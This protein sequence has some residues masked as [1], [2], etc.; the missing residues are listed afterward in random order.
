D[1]AEAHGARWNA[2]AANVKADARIGGSHLM[3]VHQHTHL[4]ANPG[5]GA[6]GHCL[7]KDFAAFRELF[8]KVLA[9]DKESIAVLRA[10]ET[11]NIKLLKESGKDLDL[12]AGVYGDDV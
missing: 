7:I 4:S 5:R 1:L 6:G 3:P 12:L 10:L 11:K 2:I 8:E 9:H